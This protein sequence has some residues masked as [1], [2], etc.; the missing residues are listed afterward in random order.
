MLQRHLHEE[1]RLA[2]NA[3]TRAHN[4]H[5]RDQADFFRRGGDT[6]FPEELELLGDVTGKS[7]V[8][9][10]CNAGQDSLSLAR[11][12]ASVTGVDISDEAIAFAQ[13]LS[14]ESG[15]PATFIRS[16]LYDWFEA[17]AARGERYDVAFCSYG[18]L[19]WL[20]DLSAWARGVASILKPG[21]RLVLVE[22][23]PTALI[24]EEDWSIGYPYFGHGQALK[25]EEGVHDYVARAGEGLA[26]SG[27]EAG[28]VDFHN[29]YPDNEF[30]FSMS[31]IVEGV[32]AAGLRLTALREW[33][34]CNGAAMWADMRVTEGRRMF[35]PER[36]PSLPLMLG[37]CAA[38]SA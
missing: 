14:A 22:F 15:I 35:P 24:F 36:L 10:Q 13:R 6:L 7:L 33:P 2:W 34:Y 1:N 28:E 23:H 3:A 8:H 30:P 29:P 21:G 32:L 20:S 18:A 26:V 4:S 19:G 9:M 11:R 38:K 16:D 27:Y 31:E 37:L 25:C 12:G 17:A 5:K